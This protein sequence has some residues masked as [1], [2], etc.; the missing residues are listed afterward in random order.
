M[1]R[2]GE[3]LYLPPG[4][5]HVPETQDSASLHFTLTLEPVSFW[6]LLNPS[7]YRALLKHSV[8]FN[9]DMRFLDKESR[10]TH[11]TRQR[12]TFVDF[13]SNLSTNELM[14]IYLEQK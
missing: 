6:S 13:I 1:L 14:D 5:Y 2:P 11:L 9:E 8:E 10:N 7:V 4:H 3:S 12:D